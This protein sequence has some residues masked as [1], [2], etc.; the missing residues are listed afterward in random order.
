ML[1]FFYP[2]LPCIK[3][4]EM[5]FWLK[6]KGGPHHARA[7]LRMAIWT[8]KQHLLGKYFLLHLAMGSYNLDSIPAGQTQNLYMKNAYPI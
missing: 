2:D 8:E 1:R 5:V 4:R 3:G 6:V 7:V